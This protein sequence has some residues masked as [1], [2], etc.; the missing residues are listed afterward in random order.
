MLKRNTFEALATFEDGA[1]LRHC[2]QFYCTVFR[3]VCLSL[4]HTHTN[5]HTHA[6]IYTHT[7]THTHIQKP[8]SCPT[9][10]LASAHK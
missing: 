5:T 1:L 10:L 7:H 4:S 6:D 9:A 2:V 8:Q 3:V